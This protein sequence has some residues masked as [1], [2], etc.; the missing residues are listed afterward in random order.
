MDA[1][2]L[3]AEQRERL[4]SD[5]AAQVDYLEK[6]IQRMDRRQWYLSDPVR[7]SVESAYRSLRAA[8]CSLDQAKQL[9]PPQ[10]RVFVDGH[11]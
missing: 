3:T 7:L 1:R 10:S 2:H 6:L 5:L 8:I 11:R 9:P 4:A